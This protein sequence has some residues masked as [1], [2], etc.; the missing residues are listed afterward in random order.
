MD[1]TAIR[2]RLKSSAEKIVESPSLGAVTL[3]RLPAPDAVRFSRTMSSYD[4]EDADE[5]C[6]FQAAMIAVSLVEDGVTPFDNDEGREVL[7]MLPAGELTDLFQAANDLNGL[8][9]IKR[10]AEKN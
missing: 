2:A 3:R 6:A 1:I 9:T 10:N 8:V 4:M 5:N 7:G